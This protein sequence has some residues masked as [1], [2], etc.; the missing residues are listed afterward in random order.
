M[1]QRFAFLAV[2]FSALTTAASAMTITTTLLTVSDKS[3]ANL[4]GFASPTPNVI[5][6]LSSNV[7][8]NTA[9]NNGG[10]NVWQS[11]DQENIAPYSSLVNSVSIEYLFGS[12]QT[13]FSLLWGSIDFYNSIELYSGGSIVETIVPGATVIAPGSQDP[14]FPAAG[15]HFVVVSGTSFDRAVFGTT[16]SAFE[17]A[18]LSFDAAPVPLPAGIW[19]LLSVL[20]IPML[21][22]RG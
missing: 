21:R 7:R 22:R 9:N 4:P 5:N 2:V 20:A 12:A 11:T 15:D 19:L 14:N 13:G 18:N 16:Q 8:M 3:A 17:F 10:I 6:G 1:F